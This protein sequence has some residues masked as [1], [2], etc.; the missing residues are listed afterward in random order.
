VVVNAQFAVVP[1]F[2]HCSFFTGHH[3]YKIFVVVVVVLFNFVIFGVLD[4]VGVVEGVNVVFGVVLVTQGFIWY[5]CCRCW[6]YFCWG[7]VLLG[8]C[9][10]VLIVDDILVDVGV[11]GVNVLVVVVVD[12]VCIVVFVTQPGCCLCLCCLFLLFLL[13][14]LLVLLVVAF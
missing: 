13:N 12:V 7:F 8:F 4:Y 6:Y 14:L 5:F 9:F 10:V 3:K 2:F 11:N 1:N